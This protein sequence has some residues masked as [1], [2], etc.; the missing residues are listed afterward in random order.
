MPGLLPQLPPSVSTP[1]TVPSRVGLSHAATIVTRGLLRKA[2]FA[3]SPS[4]RR[5]SD[6]TA[7]SETAKKNP[8]WPPTAVVT[9][10][11]EI[12]R[13][14]ELVEGLLR[15][16]GAF[17][18]MTTCGDVRCVVYITLFYRQASRPAEELVGRGTTIKNVM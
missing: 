2:A 4:I 15:M 11:D 7:V 3:V 13:R 10:R 14:P 1:R 5:L 12:L 6:F 18:G 17:H 16:T 9:L 8:S